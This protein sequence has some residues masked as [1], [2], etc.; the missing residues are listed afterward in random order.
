MT[1]ELYPVTA[2]I[3]A[4]A[5][6]YSSVVITDDVLISVPSWIIFVNVG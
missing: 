2:G 5:S 4:I 1:E 3:I 6:S